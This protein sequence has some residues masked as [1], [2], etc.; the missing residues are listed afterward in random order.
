MLLKRRTGKTLKIQASRRGVSAER[1]S[2]KQKVPLR[3]KRDF[4]STGL[5]EDLFFRGF[6][7][8]LLHAAGRSRDRGDGEV[9]VGDDRAR[10]LRQRD[11]RDVHAVADLEAGEVDG[12]GVRDVV[13]ERVQL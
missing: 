10:A 9:A 1:T 3:G 2:R 5:A 11:V 8:V 13:G 6:F 7:L 12:D 4:A